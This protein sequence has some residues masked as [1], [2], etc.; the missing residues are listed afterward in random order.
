LKPAYAAPNLLGQSALTL[1][2]QGALAPWN[3]RQAVLLY[4]AL[5]PEHRAKVRAASGL[6]LAKALPV[7]RARIF[8]GARDRLANMWSRVLDSPFRWMSFVH[9]ARLAG[10]NTPAKIRSL[11]ADEAKLDDLLEVSKRTRDAMIDYTNLNRTEATILRRVVFFYPWLAGSGRYTGRFVRDHPVQAAALAELAREGQQKAEKDLGP[12]P[13]YARGS[14]KVGEDEQGRPLVVNPR[15]AQLFESPAQAFDVARGIVSGDPDTERIEGLLTPAVGAVGQLI[16]PHDPLGGYPLDSTLEGLSR[17][18]VEGL[19]QYRLQ[20]ELRHPTDEDEDRL[21][22]TSRAGALAKFGAGTIYPRPVNPDVLRERAFETAGSHAERMRIDPERAREKAERDRL[23][24]L[25]APQRATARVLV[26][27]ENMLLEAR[28][29]GLLG[30]DDRLPE[31]LRQAWVLQARRRA[32]WAEAEA[33]LDEPLTGRPL[34]VLRWAAEVA[35]ALELGFLDE[36]QAT[37]SL[38]AAQS[39]TAEELEQ[40]RRLVAEEY[41]GGDA[42]AEARRQIREAGGDL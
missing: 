34:Q 17:E 39:M 23:A 33:D 11:L 27:R 4:R 14:F 30:Q 7:E 36:Q 28:R 16:R 20:E 9:E 8:R 3:A 35:L 19:P 29:L 1:I 24:S 22:P 6:G 26:E 5:T 41:F 32:A 15:A 25:P 38:R 40:A 31:P 37:E 13:W 21:Y 12:V 10:Y 42:I 2:E 18:M